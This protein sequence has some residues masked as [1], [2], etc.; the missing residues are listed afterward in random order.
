M[1]RQVYVNGRYLPYHQ[2]GVHVEDRGFQF[3]DAV[4]E[5][6]EVHNSQ[7]IDFPRH[8]ARLRH[9]LDELDIVL[10]VGDG[11]L[12]HI[13]R[14][15]V[16]RNR[17][18]FGSVYLQVSRGKAK[19]DFPFPTPQGP[20]TLVCLARASQPERIAA[21]AATGI[22]IITE[23]DPRWQRCDI[24]TVMLLPAVLAKQRAMTAGAH[25]VWFV[26]NDG[27]VTE[28][29]S[30]TAWIVASDKTVITRPLSQ[31]IL[32]GVTR[33][34]VLDQLNA[35]GFSLQ[36]RAF[37]VA[38]AETAR[39]AFQTSASGTVLPVVKINGRAIGDGVPG[40]LTLTLRQRFHKYAAVT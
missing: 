33:A 13:M 20:A 8:L 34:T 18:R 15:T 31:R 9:S 29:A 4:Y 22:S 30:S 14:E 27:Q 32:P 36:E 35:D 25:E 37:S 28:G 17:V 11:A 1:T 10:S 7:I 40:P 5:V 26:D 39:E 2:A 24:K 23:P 16:R 19:R 12:R 3:A 6:C 21:L 38:D